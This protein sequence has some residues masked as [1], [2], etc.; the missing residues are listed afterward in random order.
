MIF[1]KK[2]ILTA[3]AVLLCNG[4][5]ICQVFLQL[6]R[7]N[8]PKSIKF[9]RGEILEY[10][11]FEY[12]GVWKKHELLDFK[13]DEQLVI[14]DDQFYKTSDFSYVRLEYPVV[15][16]LGTR[17]MQFS[18]AWYAYG[19][20]ATVASDGYTMGSQEILL[21]AGVALTGFIMRSF[22][23]RRKVWLGKNKRLRVMDLRMDPERGF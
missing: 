15:R 1:Q 20:I 6:E 9:Q 10:Q 19:G 7:P 4:F 23:Y 2:Y 21:G 22:L 3:I 8:N 5:L 11:L 12:P 13:A 18:A 17:L 14:L 16:G